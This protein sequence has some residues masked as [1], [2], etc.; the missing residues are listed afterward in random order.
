M[1]GRSF[2]VS[3]IGKTAA[4]LPR[5]QNSCMDVHQKQVNIKTRQLFSPILVH[6][7][8][9]H[10]YSFD[11]VALYNVMCISRKIAS[12]FKR[13]REDEERCLFI[14][15]VEGWS[16]KRMSLPRA[17]WF[18]MFQYVSLSSFVFVHF[19]LKIQFKRISQ[20][21]IDVRCKHSLLGI[22]SK[23]NLLLSS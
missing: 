7:E 8:H 14:I 20:W 13:L 6:F 19:C 10:Y 17:F 2:E 15:C 5:H 1:G 12:H 23:G 11:L 4:K 21:C 16:L 9:C 3:F 22:Q 18:L